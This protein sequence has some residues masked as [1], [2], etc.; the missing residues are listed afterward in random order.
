LISAGRAQDRR[1]GALRVGDH[2]PDFTLSPSDGG[3]PI[4]LSAFRGQRPVALVFGSY[5]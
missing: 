2:A 4:T 1:D 5:T 3:L